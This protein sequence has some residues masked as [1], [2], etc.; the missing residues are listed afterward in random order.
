MDKKKK[1]SRKT[2]FKWASLALMLPFF[3]VWQ[4]TVSRN[5]S[6]ASSPQSL[7]IDTDLPEGVYFHKRVIL[8]KDSNGLK[9]FSSKCTHLGC[10]INKIENGELVCPCHGSRYSFDGNPVKGP[11]VKQLTEID[12][13]TDFLED[14]I[15]LR[16]KL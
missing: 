13:E 2:F 3:K 16:Y 8:V 12:F 11:S 10:T 1:I 9:L 14:R 6:F 4:N 15:V 5:K 7:E